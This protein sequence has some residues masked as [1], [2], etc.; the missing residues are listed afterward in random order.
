[1]MTENSLDRVGNF[2]IEISAFGNSWVEIDKCTQWKLE[3][4]LNLAGSY[5]QDDINENQLRLIEY[6]KKG[7]KIIT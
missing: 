6:T 5:I 7:K 2:A 4:A 3:D 1:M